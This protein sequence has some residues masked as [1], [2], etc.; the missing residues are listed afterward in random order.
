M[1]KKHP[2]L[3]SITTLLIAILACVVPGAA[4]APVAVDPNAVNTSIV[5]TISARQTQEILNNPPT[6]T[7]TFT[8][9][10]PTQTAESALSPIPDFTATSSIPE[11]SVSV[12][13][14]CRV[15]PGAIFERVGILLVGETAE[16]VGREPKGE[17]WY[18]RNPDQD[19]EYCWVWGEYAT[20][21]GNTLPLLYLSPPPP[22]SAAFGASFD[23]LETCANYWVDFKL[24]NTSG[25]VFKSVSIILTDTDTDPVTVVS[26]NAN[27]FAN[28][29]ACSSP[30]V[31]ENL[32][33][34]SFV[35]VSSP[36]LAYNLT[37]HNLNAKITICTEKDQKGTCI[38]QELTFKP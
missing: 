27:G 7:F 31:T 23:K 6:A 24:V 34:G 4:P 38:T 3:I 36:Q 25:A 26:K 13:T 37:G 32:V 9:E 22:P 8:P 17:F 20:V 12:D 35:T 29:D 5:Q 21:S 19:T 15:G 33:A 1:L 11:I 14:N 16:I 10:T 30:V 18:I 2:V 28:G